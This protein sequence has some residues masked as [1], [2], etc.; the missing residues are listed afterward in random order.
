MITKEEI[1][2]LPFELQETL[3]LY[4]DAKKNGSTMWDCILSQLDGDI[5]ICESSRLITN[6]MADRLRE[7]FLPSNTPCLKAGACKSP[8]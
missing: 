7:E 4:Y 8:D 2:T 1:Y 5:N 6:E 3:K